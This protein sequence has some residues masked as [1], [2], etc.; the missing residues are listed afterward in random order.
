MS[1]VDEV[2]TKSLGNT[3]FGLSSILFLA[4]LPGYEIHDGVCVLTGTIELAR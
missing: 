2:Y 4:C 1:N 3:V